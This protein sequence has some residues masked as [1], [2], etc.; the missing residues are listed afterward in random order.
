M[1]KEEK[2]LLRNRI[3]DIRNSLDK[4][5]KSFMDNEI[6]NRLIK[7][8]LYL[9]AK[10][11]FIY[12]NF[13]SEIDTMSIINKALEDGKD[14]YIPKIYRDNK[15]MKAIKINGFKDLEK[16]S[17]GILEPIN[18]SSY[19]SKEKLDLIIVPGAVFD[20]SGNRIGYGGGYYDRYLEPIE[21]INNKLVLAYELQIVDFIDSESHDIK[22]DYVI[23]NTKF[24][25]IKK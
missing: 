9:K 18:D 19:I 14:V 16:N 21:N 10:S 24:R 5:T 8:E 25:K 3:L 22:F 2:R 1:N 13:G 4:D 7:S 20:L 15:S 6:Y 12:I 17:M 23:T 11:I